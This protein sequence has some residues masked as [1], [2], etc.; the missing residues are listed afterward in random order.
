MSLFNLAT[1][2][3]IPAARS[4]LRFLSKMK[5]PPGVTVYRG[6]NVAHRHSL[7]EA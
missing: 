6:Q 3:G 2:A 5:K 4:A 1:K 7:E